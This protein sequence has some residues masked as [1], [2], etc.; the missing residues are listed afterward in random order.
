MPSVFSHQILNA[1]PYAF[2]DDAPIEERRARAV[3]MRRVLP[4]QG[5]DLG[6]SPR[7]LSGA[8]RKTPGGSA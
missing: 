6:T 4:E 3:F 8:R 5:S 7:M 2:L 1:M